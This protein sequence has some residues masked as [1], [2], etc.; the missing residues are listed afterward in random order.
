[1]SDSYKTIRKKAESLLKEKGSK[2]YGFSFHV[3]N[4]S[5]VQSRLEQVRKIHHSARHHCYAYRLGLDG[6]DYRSNDDGEPNH[7]AGDPIHR[8]LLSLELTYCL[9]IVVRYFGGT[10]LGVGGL[11]SAY[12]ES[13]KAALLEAGVK[14][15]EN[16]FDVKVAFA[17]AQ[18]SD[19]MRVLKKYDLEMSEHAFLINC[20]LTCPVPFRIEKEVMEELEAIPFIQIKAEDH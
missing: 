19:V 3:K 9:V 7:S 15:V 11:I 8:Q 12:G 14:E 2:F 10:K 6:E 17:Y 20:S 18:M 4:E 16:T 5:D 1:M 13:A